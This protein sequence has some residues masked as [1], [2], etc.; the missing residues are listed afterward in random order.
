M[1]GWNSNHNAD[2]PWVQSV[3]TTDIYTKEQALIAIRMSGLLACTFNSIG[4]KMDLPY[5]G[6]GVLGVCN[7][8]AALVDYA[9]RG[10]TNMYPL[11][12]TGRYLLHTAARL[13][14]MWQ[15]LSEYDDM[16]KEAADTKRLA[17]A[18]CLMESDIHCSP[19]QLIGATRRYLANYPVSFFQLTEDSKEVMTQLSRQYQDFLADKTPTT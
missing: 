11:L 2:V 5:G 9:V 19:S 16:K 6:Y 4:T 14:G 8:T 12:S 13:V 3:S 10:C 7:D 15:I 18:A 17:T 1:C